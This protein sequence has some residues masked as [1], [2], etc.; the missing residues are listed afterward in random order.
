MDH[1]RRKTDD[2]EARE[3][4]ITD[5]YTKLSTQWM[6]K[7]ERVENSRKRK[8]RDAKARELYEKVFDE[9]RKQREN[10]ERDHRLGTRGAVRSEADIEDVIERLQWIRK[11][12]KMANDRFQSFHMKYS[13]EHKLYDD[14]QISWKSV[15]VKTPTHFLK[16]LAV[17]RDWFGWNRCPTP[18]HTAVHS[19]DL[20]LF[21][22]IYEKSKD[23]NPQDPDGR[24]PF[25]AAAEH[26]SLEIFKFI[27]EKAE[28]KNPSMKFGRTTLHLAAAHGHLEICKL[29]CENISSPDSRSDCGCL[30]SGCLNSGCLNCGLNCPCGNFERTPLHEAAINGHLE[31][32]KIIAERV[33]EINPKDRNGN[34]PLR[35]AEEKGHHEICRLIRSLPPYVSI[36]QAYNQIKQRDAKLSNPEK[37]R[38]KKK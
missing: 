34:T 27:M 19:G 24:T 37:K 38:R 14:H 21:E 1:F 18:L 10:K 25:H 30:N 3:R 15:L 32:Y 17:T 9:L 31:I 8:D 5:S 26:G 7:V 33:K 2:K 12:Q 6:K 29:I 28:G 23:K 11:I 22:H 13:Y 4:Y 20:Q 16:K 36:F 35:L